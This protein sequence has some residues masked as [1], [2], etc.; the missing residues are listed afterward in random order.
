VAGL[1]VVAVVAAVLTYRN[2]VATRPRV[3][4]APAKRTSRSA[5]LD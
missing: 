2:W 1:G 5:F 3:V 4:A